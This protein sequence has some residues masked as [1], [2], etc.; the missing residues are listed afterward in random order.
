[1]SERQRTLA[2]ALL[3]AGLGARAYQTARNAM[4]LNETLAEM[5]GLPLEFG[6][7]FYW[8]SFFGEPS[9]DAPWG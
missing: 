3:R 4:R 2:Y 5:T 8:I 6:E 1:L 9:P 7:Y